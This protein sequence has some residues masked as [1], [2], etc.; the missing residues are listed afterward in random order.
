M[1]LKAGCTYSELGLPV[2]WAVAKACLRSRDIVL[3]LLLFY[4]A[5]VV[6]VFD[7]VISLSMSVTYCLKYMMVTRSG[8]F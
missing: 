4:L 3:N 7:A 5:S 6:L 8:S 2:A 1:R